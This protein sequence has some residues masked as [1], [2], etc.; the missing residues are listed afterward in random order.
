M[1]IALLDSCFSFT[2]VGSGVSCLEGP[3]ETSSRFP[4]CGECLTP[5]PVIVSTCILKKH[6]LC[7]K[8]ALMARELWSLS[9]AYWTIPL[10]VEWRDGQTDIAS[11]QIG[12]GVCLLEIQK[13]TATERLQAIGGEFVNEQWTLPRQYLE[14]FCREEGEVNPESVVEWRPPERVKYRKLSMS[15]TIRGQQ[16]KGWD[17]FFH[18]FVKAGWISTPEAAEV[19]W[20]AFCKHALHWLANEQKPVDMGFCQICPVPLRGNWKALLLQS[21]LKS[22]V[23][24]PRVA[25]SALLGMVADQVTKPEFNAWEKPHR[26]LWG[27]EVLPEKAWYRAS[28]EFEANRWPHDQQP[29]HRRMQTY[30]G[31]VRASIKR[32]LPHLTKLYAAYLANLKNPGARLVA[33]ILPSGKAST[34]VSQRRGATMAVPPPDLVPERYDSRIPIQ[35]DVPQGFEDTGS[36]DNDLRSVSDLRQETADMR[37]AGC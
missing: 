12:A 25:N 13:T 9:D 18:E 20:L 31:W 3:L 6:P 15:A 11:V 28:A 5:A 17:E 14:R 34:R 2:I 19:L 29:C 36:A 16:T 10:W 27:L 21:H 1:D 26:M 22:G 23:Q 35:D 7:A 32:A 33:V 37:G 4:M 24:P 8:H 30:C